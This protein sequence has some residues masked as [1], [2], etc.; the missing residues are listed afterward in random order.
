MFLTVSHGK[1]EAVIAACL[2][3]S[4]FLTAVCMRGILSRE[5]YL[6]SVGYLTETKDGSIPRP[7][8][9][10]LMSAELVRLAA[11]WTVRAFMLAPAFVC[12]RFG[13]RYYSLSAD[14]DGLMLMTAAA[15]LLA[16]GGV[17]FSA[18]IRSGLACAEYL[19]MHGECRDMLSALDGSWELT[20]GDCGDMLRLIYLSF[21][22]APGIS[23]LCVMNFSHHLLLRKGMPPSDGPHLKL[24]CNG[25][26]E[27]QIEI[28]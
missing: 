21:F 10:A 11:V 1:R 7:G 14:R 18:V 26:G 3:V 27:Q 17:L 13:A 20:R 28:I 25:R 15:L 8:I 22:S 4:A 5:M 16:A 9:P 2:A 23:G 24:V 6:L 19:W 12:F